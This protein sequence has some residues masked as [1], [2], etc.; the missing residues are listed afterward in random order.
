RFGASRN[1]IAVSAV[2]TTARATRSRAAAQGRLAGCRRRFFPGLPV[3]ISG[4]D[5]VHFHAQRWTG[6][7]S[8]QCHRHRD[9]V[10]DGL[11]LRAH[12]RASP[13]AGGY[14]DGCP[15]VDSRGPD[16]GVGRMKR[17]RFPSLIAIAVVLAG[18]NALAQETA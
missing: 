12:D 10:F 15:W 1:G 5:S 17:M 13:V 2:E 14:F 6:P 8:F 7:S 18:D 11:R 16:H 9:V 4:G 3:Y